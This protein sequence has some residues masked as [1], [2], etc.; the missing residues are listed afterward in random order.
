MVY[1]TF[2]FPFCRHCSGERFNSTPVSDEISEKVPSHPEGISRDTRGWAGRD[3]HTVQCIR[4]HR[5]IHIM[6]PRDL[7]TSCCGGRAMLAGV[8]RVRCH[9]W[10]ENVC[11][12]QNFRSQ[13]EDTC[14]LYKMQCS[15]MLCVCKELLK[16][17]A[18]CE[19]LLKRWEKI[20]AL[21]LLN[22]VSCAF[23]PLKCFKVFL[24]II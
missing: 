15:F 3:C 19:I 4:R 14:V 5:A 17:M 18:H 13:S 24:F 21:F 22:G 16:K 1:K 23:T 7:C 8:F 11:P 20:S 9:K 12:V 6:W 2:F 10:E